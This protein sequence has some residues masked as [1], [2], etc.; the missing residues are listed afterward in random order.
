MAGSLAPGRPNSAPP[1]PRGAE[2]TRVKPISMLPNLLT[3]ANS[4]C[5]LLAISKGIDALAYTGDDPTTAADDDTSTGTGPGVAA[6]P[7]AVMVL[8]VGGVGEASVLAVPLCSSPGLVDTTL[9]SIA[10]DVAVLGQLLP[11]ERVQ[12]V[13]IEAAAG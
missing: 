11:L 8:G 12:D 2:G 5:G 13:E 10:P 9:G 4:A 3:L 6:P 7:V 1:G